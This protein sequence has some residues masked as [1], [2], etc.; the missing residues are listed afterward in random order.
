MALCLAAMDSRD[1][2]L[3][4][5]TTFFKQIIAVFAFG[6][7]WKNT[8]LRA[9]EIVCWRFF[10]V[11]LSLFISAYFIYFMKVQY[12]QKWTSGGLK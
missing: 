5:A 12:F 9:L 8:V 1:A 7:H 3:A 4:S 10:S 11:Y 2:S 6:V